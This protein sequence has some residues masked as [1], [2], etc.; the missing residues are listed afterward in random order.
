MTDF[1]EIH[2]AGAEKILLLPIVFLIIF[3]LIKNYLK[4]K[5]AYELLIHKDNHKL[6]FQSFS[7]RRQLLKTI[8]LTIA[9]VAIFLA[10]LQPQWGK[11]ETKIAQEGRDLLILLDISRSM[12]AKDLKPNRLEFTKLKIKN[13]LKKLDFERVGLILF[14]GTAFLQCPLTVDHAA[15]LMFLDQV[16]VET[17]AS[18]STAI[19]SALNK[20][21]EVYDHS[22]RK[23]KLVV[24]ATDGEDFSLNL[25]EIK[26]K[27]QA[28]NIK[29]FALGIGTL[30]GGPVPILDA[31]GNI[32]GHEVDGKGNIVLTTL[33]ENMLQKMCQDLLGVYFRSSYDDSDLTQLVSVI[34]GYEKEKFDDKKMSYYQ[35]QYSW[36]LGVAFIF[37]L[38]EWIL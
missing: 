34:K 30:Q 15:F 16:D 36:F 25:E 5:N 21:I 27:A 11:K 7:I 33:N 14:S 35:D 37:L 6:L 32:S 8:F 4:N 28:K 3:I 31:Q 20:A 13:F 17:I 24:L 12:L 26:R 9:V 38:L 18:G 22:S 1:L 23:N 2:F 10:M 19:D 29:L